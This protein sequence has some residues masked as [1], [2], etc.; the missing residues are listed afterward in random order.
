LLFAAVSHAQV[1]LAA[2][3][4]TVPKN[5]PLTCGIC[6]LEVAIIKATKFVDNTIVQ[7]A[8]MIKAGKL[9]TSTEI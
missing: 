6:M 4:R 7:T 5:T 1:N 2:V 8:K 3:P 9:N